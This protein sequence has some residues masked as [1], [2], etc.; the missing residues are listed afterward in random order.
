MEAY[1]QLKELKLPGAAIDFLNLSAL[2][3]LEVFH[4]QDTKA[5]L[6]IDLSQ[7]AALNRVEII[8]GSNIRM[9][10]HP[11]AIVGL[12][13]QDSYFK[14]L[15]DLNIDK[16]KELSLKNVKLMDNELLKTQNPYLEKIDISVEGVSEKGSDGSTYHSLVFDNNFIAKINAAAPNLKSLSVTFANSELYQQADFS[17]LNL[18]LLEKFS[19]EII[20]ENPGASPFRSQTENFELSRCPKLKEFSLSGLYTREI[21]LSQLTT[22]YN[23][24][25]K[26]IR[27]VAA[28]NK[29][30][31]PENSNEVQVNL[32]L[33]RINEVIVPEAAKQKHSLLFFDFYK[34]KIGEAIADNIDLDW[35]YLRNLLK[36]VSGYMDPTPPSE[37]IP[38]SDRE[39]VVFNN[40]VLDFSGPQWKNFK[41][42]VSFLHRLWS[43]DYTDIDYIDFGHLTEANFNTKTISVNVGC[44]VKNL[45]DGLII[46]Q[47]SPY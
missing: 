42:K 41:G 22:A 24:E 30:Y 12:K 1:Y 9:K 19:I 26:Q 3:K 47:I 8:S 25:L 27:I 2:N 23:P 43:I 33:T 36:S 32:A 28:T 5:G 20:D 16:V 14:N 39:T 13:I 4:I 6:E 46:K 40:K 31:L 34:V 17:G 10:L 18:P 37:F 35:N 29:L 11:D 21:N 38:A 7:S 44:I 45:P 15:S